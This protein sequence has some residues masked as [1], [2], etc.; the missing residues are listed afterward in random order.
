MKMAMLINLKSFLK[1]IYFDLS[2]KSES[3]KI[4][5]SEKWSENEINNYHYNKL[6]KVL[7]DAFNNVVYYKNLSKKIKFKLADFKTLDDFRKMPLLDRSDIKKNPRDF[8]HNRFRKKMSIASTGGSSGSALDFYSTIDHQIREYPYI[9]YIFSL[10]GY[11]FNSPRMRWQGTLVDKKIYREGYIYNPFT[12]LLNCP[13]HDL[14]G[15]FITKCFDKAKIHKINIL[16]GYPTSLQIIA[17][18]LIQNKIKYKNIKMCM[19]VSEMV[20]PSHRNIVRKA[21]G[22]RLYSFYGQSER[23]V[24]ATECE[25]SDHYHFFPTFSYV[26]LIKENGLPAKEDGDVGEII[27]TGY[28]IPAYPLIR[29][30]TGDIG[31]LCTKK[32][33]CG[34]N[35]LNIYRITGRAG[36]TIKLRNGRFL[37]VT[38]LF[39]GPHHDFLSKLERF[40]CVQEIPGELEFYI[41]SKNKIDES[42]KNKLSTHLERCVQEKNLKVKVYQIEYLPYTK[43]NK[44]RLIYKKDEIKKIKLI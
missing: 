31:V 9:D 14:S 33:D 27:A 19:A 21:F 26:E 32:C 2:G 4:L 22:C 15:N 43:N 44:H 20:L 29:Y 11:K 8:I 3:K 10:N 41:V 7:Y 5:N 28:H 17:N 18:H 38:A 25:Y 30:R 34:R 16:H 40:A 35:W 36:E 13:S 24:I 42:K 39:Y 6:K 23:S 12:K 1:Q 37:P